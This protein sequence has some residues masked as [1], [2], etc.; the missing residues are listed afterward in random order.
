MHMQQLLHMSQMF[1]AFTAASWLASQGA[2]NLDERSFR[3]VGHSKGP[4]LTIHQTVGETGLKVWRRLRRWLPIMLKIMTPPKI[5]KPQ[6]VHGMVNKW[7]AL[8]HENI[9]DRMK[10]EFLIHM[11]LD[12]LQDGIL[13][14]CQQDQTVKREGGEPRERQGETPGRGRCEG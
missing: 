5:G 7:E 14:A 3:E 8:V 1:E 2:R 12:E 4:P 6:D 11:I 10:I 13:P 9:S